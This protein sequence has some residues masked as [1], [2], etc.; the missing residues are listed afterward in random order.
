MDP[1]RHRRSK[2]RRR[3]RSSLDTTG[4]SNDDV[5]PSVTNANKI[6]VIGLVAFC[7]INVLDLDSLVNRTSGA[8]GGGQRRSLLSTLYLAGSSTLLPWAQ[9]HMVDVTE[10]PDV[11][12]TALFWRELFLLPLMC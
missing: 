10:R 4:A 3:P 5:S 7:F 11:S 9:H 6:I 1:H 2:R 12:E 8:T